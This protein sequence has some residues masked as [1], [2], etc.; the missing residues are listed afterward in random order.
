MPNHYAGFREYLRYAKKYLSLAENAIERREDA[1]WLLIPAIIIAW[2]A[3]E[4]FVNNRCSDL[5]SLPNDM[6][7]LHERA[8]LLEKRL[9]F[10]DK[11]A[12]IGKFVL[13]GQEYHT[14]ENKIF[15]LL[16]RMGSKKTELKGEILW[17]RFQKF[18]EVRDSLVH[19][20]KSRQPDLQPDDVR[21]HIETAK[22]LIQEISK[23]IWRKPLAF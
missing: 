3:I 19:P 8:F 10:E 15:F 22:E 1:E 2:S 20:R 14:L 17:V 5:N 21:N 18:K 16:S 9:R 13:E 23:R 11:G 6:F 4:S 12:N 7:Q